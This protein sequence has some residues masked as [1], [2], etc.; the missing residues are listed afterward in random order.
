MLAAGSSVLTSCGPV[1]AESLVV[2]T[3]V[4]CLG[5]SGALMTA[6]VLRSGDDRDRPAI[7]L[8]T[9]SGDIL[10]PASARLAASRGPV[11]AA[12]IK[13]GPRQIESLKPGQASDSFPPPRPL[14]GLPAA[15]MV[16]PVSQASRHAVEAGLTAAGV[17]YSVRGSEEWVVVDIDA[18]GYCRNW[19]WDDEVALLRLLTLW[20]DDESRTLIGERN[21]RGRLLW[22]MIAAGQHYDARWVPAYR[23]VECRV[24]SAERVDVFATVVR[25]E[26]TVV[27]C[28]SLQVDAAALI[29]DRAYVLP[30]A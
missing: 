30:D 3:S 10:V 18:P 14:E 29:V 27:A 2:G 16:V 11:V 7:Q 26:P 13:P 1:D 24:C 9:R 17:S 19:K 6:E 22:A 8:L 23:P 25:S 21:I 15:R 4:S 20:V 5:T 12:S 28:R